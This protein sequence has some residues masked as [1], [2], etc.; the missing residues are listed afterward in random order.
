MLMRLVPQPR[1]SATFLWTALTFAACQVLSAQSAP[2]DAPG[3]LLFAGTSIDRADWGESDIP[4]HGL[5]VRGGVRL[6]AVDLSLAGEHWRDWGRIRAS[7][8]LLEADYFP[9]GTPVVSPYVL[10]G[11]G[12][13]WR[14]SLRPGESASSGT[15]ATAGLGVQLKLFHSAAVRAEAVARENVGSYTGQLR[16]ALGYAGDSPPLDSGLP[17]ANVDLVAFGMAPL[18]GPWRLIEPGYFIRYTRPYSERVS[19]TFA[20]GVLHWQIP[21]R[22][23]PTQYLW[24]TR[25]F[26]GMP[27]VQFLLLPEDL[28]SLRGGPAITAMGE[29][30]DAGANVGAHFEV[31]ST[32][33]PVG[34]A[35]TLG[36]GSLWMP[37][38]TGTDS[39]VSPGEDQIGLTFFGGLQL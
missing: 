39:R 4:G 13:I 1:R 9:L 37:R 24:D 6:P 14:E 10:F 25:A 3:W 17:S 16:F 31:A 38:S 34:I 27:G 15:A 36:L 35:I 20:F 19:G 32:L 21:R 23:T 28:L 18:R 29:G 30:P 7:S 2:T 11:F 33:R 22:N 5:S 26:V 8:V 12:Y